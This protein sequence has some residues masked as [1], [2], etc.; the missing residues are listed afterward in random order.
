MSQEGI[1]PVIDLQNANIAQVGEK[2]LTDFPCNN[3][4]NVKLDILWHFKSYRFL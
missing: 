4:V 1:K 2:P 3:G